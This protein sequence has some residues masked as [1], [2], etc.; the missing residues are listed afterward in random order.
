M[1]RRLYAGTSVLGGYFDVEFEEYSKRF[2]ESLREGRFVLLT[3]GVVIEEIEEGPEKVRDLFASIPVESMEVV[4]LTME[5]INLRDAYLKAGI[6]GEKWI[7]DATHVATATVAR[8]EA[9]VSWNFRHIV[10]LD[11][12]KAYNRIN[13]ANGYGYLTIVTPKEIDYGE[14]SE[15]E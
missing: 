2:V 5:I 9:I 10:R 6:L 12:M 4:P 13:L 1:K 3:S 15:P 7:D 8:A 11:K 14:S